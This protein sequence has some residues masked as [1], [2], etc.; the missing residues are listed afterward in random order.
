MSTNLEL[1]KEKDREREKVGDR[2]SKLNEKKERQRAS[3]RD[4]KQRR[5][6]FFV[7]RTT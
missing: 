1:G 4:K 3:T 7:G 6:L 5:H 2:P